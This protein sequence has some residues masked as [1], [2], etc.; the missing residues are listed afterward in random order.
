MVSSLPKAFFGEYLNAQ[1]G[2]VIEL[3]EKGVGMI[4]SITSYITKEQFR[5]S[6]RYEVRNG[7][8]FGVHATDSFPCIYEDEKYFFG[9]QQYIS[10]TETGNVLKKI[11]ERT[12]L[13]NFKEQAGYVPA[14]LVI[15]GNELQLK[16]FDYAPD[17]QVFDQVG[18]TTVSIGGAVKTTLLEPTTS[19]WSELMKKGIFEEGSS[20]RKQVSQ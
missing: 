20:Y 7:Y 1:T 15:K 17:T 19:E 6:S 18:N 9:M 11:D 4:A 2:T 14:L 13:I 3:N 12:Y 16:H 10:M 8:I 5:E